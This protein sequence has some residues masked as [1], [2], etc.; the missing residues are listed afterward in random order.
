VSIIDTLM[1]QLLI[2]VVVAHSSSVHSSRV[3][4]SRVCR[5]ARR[6]PQSPALLSRCTVCWLWRCWDVAADVA[7]CRA[8]VVD[9]RVMYTHLSRRRSAATRTFFT[10]HDYSCGSGFRPSL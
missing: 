2:V 10:C 4:C 8:S 3:H 5:A 1:V 9:Q 7:A 6:L